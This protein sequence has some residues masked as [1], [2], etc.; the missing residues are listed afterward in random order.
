MTYQIQ[1]PAHCG[2]VHRITEWSSSLTIQS[3]HP[4]YILSER[5]QTS[6]GKG[7]TSHMDNFCT[8]TSS[9]STSPAVLHNVANDLSI[10]VLCSPLPSLHVT[11]F[12][13]IFLLLVI[14]IIM[15]LYLT[16]YIYSFMISEYTPTLVLCWHFT[17]L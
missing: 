5:A 16:L 9:S 10:C 1:A 2:N 17:Y 12:Y 7:R 3:S 11:D 15:Y 4:D 8:S 6:D 13:E 14:I